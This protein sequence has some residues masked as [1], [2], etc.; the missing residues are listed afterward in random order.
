MKAADRGQCNNPQ[1]QPLALALIPERGHAGQKELATE[2]GVED[3]PTYVL[4]DGAEQRAKWT[5]VFRPDQLEF[6]AAGAGL[7]A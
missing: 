5:G 6:F 1:P 4:F 7:E 2:L 3:I